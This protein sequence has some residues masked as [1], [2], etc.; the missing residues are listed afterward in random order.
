MT[1]GTLQPHEHVRASNPPTVPM[2]GSK[3][4]LVSLAIGV[5]VIAFIALAFWFR[6]TH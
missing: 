1:I 6:A 4:E 3:S 2:G 5:V